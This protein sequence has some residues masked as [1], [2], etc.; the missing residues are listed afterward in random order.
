MAYLLEF[1]SRRRKVWFCGRY[2]L[3]KCGDSPIEWA[4]TLEL[5]SLACLHSFPVFYSFKSMKQM[6]NTIAANNYRA[7]WQRMQHSISNL[8][9][10][11]TND[12]TSLLLNESVKPSIKSSTNQ[13]FDSINIR[14]LF[15]SDTEIR[16]RLVALQSRRLKIDPTSEWLSSPFLKERWGT[17]FFSFFSFLFFSF[18]LVI[19]WS[20]YLNWALTSETILMEQV[21]TP[22]CS[23]YKL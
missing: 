7:F 16:S 18:V 11:C 10:H 5:V 22:S 23:L 14:L 3:E 19:S 12:R 13:S 15:E 1:G 6:S 4:T 9:S 2:F 17:L 21:E 20:L 8:T